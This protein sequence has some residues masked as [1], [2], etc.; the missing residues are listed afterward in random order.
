MLVPTA[1]HFCALRLAQHSLVDE[2]LS[3]ASNGSILLSVLR[4]YSTLAFPCECSRRFP[5]Y[6]D[7]LLGRPRFLGRSSSRASRNVAQLLST[8]FSIAIFGNVASTPYD[9]QSAREDT[10]TEIP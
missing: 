4:Q 6:L 2:V 5:S 10:R 7:A 8:R 3:V 9:P 1:P